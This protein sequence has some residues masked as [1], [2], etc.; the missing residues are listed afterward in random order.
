MSTESEII[1]VMVLEIGFC[2]R[3][4]PLA[5]ARTSL[6]VDTWTQEKSKDALDLHEVPSVVPYPDAL[7]LILGRGEPEYRVI[8]HTGK[9]ALA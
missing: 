3:V 9:S 6:E 4:A 2:V 7:I 5:T 8:F 1:V